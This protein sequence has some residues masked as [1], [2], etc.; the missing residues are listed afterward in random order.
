[1]DHNLMD[2]L[3]P[4]RDISAS[5]IQKYEELKLLEVPIPYSKLYRYSEIRDFNLEFNLLKR[6]TETKSHVSYL[7]QS[8]NY[9]YEDNRYSH[10]LPYTDTMV[11]LNDEKYINADFIDGPLPSLRNFFIATQGPL[12]C[13]MSNFW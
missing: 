7:I 3:L 8:G 2:G 12:T 6:I 11:R 4:S 9:P 1:M 5:F 10:I 13:T